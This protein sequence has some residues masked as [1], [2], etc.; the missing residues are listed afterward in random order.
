VKSF[1]STVT[2][3]DH[4]FTQEHDLGLKT[5]NYFTLH[6]VFFKLTPIKE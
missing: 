3:V 6:F 2:L 5:H 4:S 1:C